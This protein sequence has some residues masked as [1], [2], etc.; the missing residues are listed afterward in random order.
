MLATLGSFQAQWSK[1]TQA[2]DAVEK[3][4]ESARRGFEELNGPRRRQLERPLG[5]LEELRR[6][7]RLP[8]DEALVAD[9]ADVLELRELA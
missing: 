1:F 9:D 2:L 8:P 5:K 3:R 6:E 4:I 7:R